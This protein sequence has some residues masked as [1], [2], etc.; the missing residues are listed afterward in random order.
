MPKS[1]ELNIGERHAIIAIY[2]RGVKL[3]EIARQMGIGDTTV[4]YV[5]KRYKASGSLN[6]AQRSGRPKLLD[7]RDSRRLIRIVKKDREAILNHIHEKFSAEV[8]KWTVQGRLLKLDYKHRI[9]VK[10]PLISKLN[11]RS[12]VM[13][14]RS[15]RNWTKKQWK[16]IVL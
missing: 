10:K 12:R 7:D 14:C 4:Q 3:A 11:A 13:W 1:R 2:Q 15:R 16:R 8:S 6:S 9:A 5:I